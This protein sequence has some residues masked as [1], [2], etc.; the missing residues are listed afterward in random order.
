MSPIVPDQG[1][2]DTSVPEVPG[3]RCHH[4]VTRSPGTADGQLP[5]RKVGDLFIE[6]TGRSNMP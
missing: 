6:V 3:S 2:A 4:L 5:P 1:A